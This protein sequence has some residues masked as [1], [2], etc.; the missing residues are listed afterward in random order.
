MT[1]RGERLP[2]TRCGRLL[3]VGGHTGPVPVCRDCKDSDPDYV[4]LLLGA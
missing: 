3:T 1:R 2:C 4:A